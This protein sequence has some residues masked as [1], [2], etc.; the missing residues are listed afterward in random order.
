MSLASS[1][2]DRASLLLFLPRSSLHCECKPGHK[3][4]RTCISPLFSA[5]KLPLCSIETEWSTKDGV[6]GKKTNSETVNLQSRKGLSL[7]VRYRYTTTLLLPN[8]QQ[9]AGGAASDALCPRLALAAKKKLSSRI[10]T[11]SFSGL[12]SMKTPSATLATAQQRKKIYKTYVS[13]SRSKLPLSLPLRNQ[14]QC[15]ISVL[16]CSAPR[17]SWAWDC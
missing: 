10:P 9:K 6:C 5:S 17:A 11:F 13:C 3:L 8:L 16:V 1:E 15:F 2:V 4:V 12:F 14:V 7:N